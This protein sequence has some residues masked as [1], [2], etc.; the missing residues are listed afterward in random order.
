[1]LLLRRRLLLLLRGVT[2][3]T[4]VN[5]DF[6]DRLGSV[7]LRLD[8]LGGA[9]LFFRGAF[10]SSKPGDG[11]GCAVLVIDFYLTKERRQGGGAGGGA[12]SLEITCGLVLKVD[13]AVEEILLGFK[14]REFVEGRE[15]VVKLRVELESV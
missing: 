10:R 5:G 15:A 8:F 14:I 1:L 2:S 6:H 13:N 11:N 7:L 12:R 4:S 9:C 3:F